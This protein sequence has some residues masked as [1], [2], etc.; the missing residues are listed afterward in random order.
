MRM[1]KKLIVG[2][3][4]QLALLLALGTVA[5]NELQ[6][7]QRGAFQAEAQWQQDG[8]AS[9]TDAGAL[10]QRLENA[11]KTSR[12]FM[13]QQQKAVDDASRSLL[14]ALAGF[15][16]LGLA[17]AC[18]LV[19]S[20][21]KPLADS[22][23]FARSVTQG[24]REKRPCSNSDEEFVEIDAAINSALEALAQCTESKKVIQQEA[25]E[26]QRQAEEAQ[27]QAEEAQRQAE[28]ASR[29][30]DEFLTRMSHEV[31]TPMNAII[32]I[33][34]LCQQTPL[35]QQQRKYMQK[36]LTAANDLLGILNEILDFSKVEGGK[37]ELD[38]LPFHLNAVMDNLAR[39]ISLKARSKGLEFVFHMDRAIPPVLLGDP[40]RLTQVL[41]NLAGNA[42][43]FTDKGTVAITVH[44]KEQKDDDVLLQFSVTDTGIGL[45]DEQLRHIFQPF[46]LADGS[47]TRRHGGAGIGLSIS[48][49]LVALMGGSISAAN[50]PGGGSIFSFE[51]HLK[52]GKNY[53]AIPIRSLQDIHA[54]IVDDAPLAQQIIASN[55]TSLGINVDCASSGQEALQ[56]LKRAQETGQ[57]YHLVILD[58]RMPEMDGIETAKHIRE[59][60]LEGNPPVILMHSDYD[61]DE[62]SGKAQSA[63]ITAFLPKPATASAFYEAIQRALSQNIK[64]GS[65]HSPRM[66]GPILTDNSRVLLVEDNEI[67]QEIAC[68]LLKMA[69]VDVD[70]ASNGQE[71]IEAVERTPYAM[72]F[73]DV[74]MPVMDGLEATRRIRAAG[75]TLPIIAM[76]AHAT[77]SDRESSL[78]AGMND[79]LTKPLE[80]EAVLTTLN[81]WMPFAS[82]EQQKTAQ[83]E[84]AALQ[85]LPDS[86]AGFNLS[87]GL[88]AVGNNRK[89]YANLLGKFAAR[90]A[91]ITE[92]IASSLQSN[93]LDTAVRLAH[94][95]KGIAANLGAES[96]AEAAGAL[97]KTITHDP[98]SI[99]PH[100]TTLV[101]RLAVAISAVREALGAEAPDSVSHA[102]PAAPANLP[103]SGAENLCK[104]LEDAVQN[105]ETD[106]STA[107]R[108]TRQVCTALQGTDLEDAAQRLA[109]AVEDFETQ[110]AL[111]CSRYLQQALREASTLA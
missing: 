76:T 48:Q 62:I 39:I 47:M 32:G 101:A 50:N 2:L 12:Q 82:G 54:L 109:E 18:I 107:S 27:R 28:E 4:I 51:V 94:T 20:V 58:W 36:I 37:L 29:A 44:C 57:T 38:N 68:E 89:L 6:P 78:E 7:L 43:K 35:D 75:Y 65:V 97:E 9:A 61:F 71:A 31:R 74:Q 87:A 14:W 3:G 105:M 64:S 49:R 8:A 77:R 86:I 67:N 55:V 95:V 110:R 104:R 81:H 79:H 60:F 34:H 30:K 100:L 26:A 56:L 111:E 22:Q 46:V 69:H 66:T 45:T 93:D 1:G 90:Y 41:I 83:E 73:M 102:Q 33:S 25:Q 106:W 108:V 96:L 13:A 70:V 24:Q 98:E 80:P 21:M 23:A 103:R 91:T 92:D 52:S 63:G 11:E 16:T 42:V 15:F 53:Q 99:T 17:A 5:W 10:K 88:S 19:R 72:V 40:L 85:L 84:Q 59:A